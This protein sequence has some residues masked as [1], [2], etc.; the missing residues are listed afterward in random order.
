MIGAGA[1]YTGRAVMSA[2]SAGTAKATITAAVTRSFV[3]VFIFNPRL[4]TICDKCIQLR[5]ARADLI[6]I[7]MRNFAQSGEC[8]IGS[9][10]ARMHQNLQTRR[11][12]AVS[13]KSEALQRE[14]IFSQGFFPKSIDGGQ[15]PFTTFWLDLKYVD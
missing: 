14:R 8:G 1:L 11:V 9:A 5:A 6:E 4:A 13:C 2:A 7:K 3:L 12:F 15:N 10:V